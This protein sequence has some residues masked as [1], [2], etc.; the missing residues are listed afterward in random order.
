MSARAPRLLVVAGYDPSGAGIDADREALAGLALDVRLVVTALTEQDAGGVRRI[1]ARGTGLWL[2]EALRELPIA[3]LKFGL[4]PSRE[5]VQAAAELVRAAREA[6][7]EQPIHAVV[8]PVLASS[9]GS[10]FLSREDAREY[11]RSLLPAR[12]VLTPNLDELAEL[13]GADRERL[14]HEPQVR[15]EAARTLLEL[16]A[17]ALVVKGGHGAESPARDLVLE[18]GAPAEWLAHERIP[19]GKVRGS[20]CR[21]AARLAAK[22]ALGASLREAARE[23][24]AHVLEKLRAASARA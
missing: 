23:A 1:G 17:Q 20:G 24:S 6:A 2:P 11:L 13:T 4:L 5:D 16:G 12:V 9:S 21:F 19:G 7:G 22:L 18:R 3:A 8:D 15:V 10:R 14:V